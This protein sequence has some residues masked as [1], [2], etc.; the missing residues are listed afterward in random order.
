M[1]GKYL[2]NEGVRR[3]KE[4]FKFPAAWQAVYPCLG[5]KTCTPKLK[6]DLMIHKES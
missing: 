6:A 1:R 5:N 3:L 4:S 2:G